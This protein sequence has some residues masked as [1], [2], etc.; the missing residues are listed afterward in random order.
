MTKRAKK[1]RSPG[2]PETQIK[3]TGCQRQQV[4]LRSAPTPDPVHPYALPRVLAHEKSPIPLQSQ[5]SSK[6]RT[7]KCRK[8]GKTTVRNKEPRKSRKL[9]TTWDFGFKV[10]KTS[11]SGLPRLLSADPI[12]REKYRSKKHG[13]PYSGMQTWP[14]KPTKPG[15]LRNINNITKIDE[16]AK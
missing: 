3:R 2:P 7:C 11:E 6:G 1:C 9:G 5:A 14:F 12:T 15:N 13:H 4:Q 16:P 10:T 8:P